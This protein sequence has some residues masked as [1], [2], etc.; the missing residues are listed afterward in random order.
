[1]RVISGK[2]RGTKLIGPEGL[3][4]RPTSDRIKESLFNMIGMDLYDVCFL[5]IFSG[6]G[7]IG[8]EALSRGAKE[9]TFIEQSKTAYKS[10]EANI[11][12]TKLSQQSSILN[13]SVSKALNELGYKNFNVIFMDPPYNKDMINHTLQLIIKN[14]LLL[15]GGYII[16]ERP[17]SYKIDD[18]EQLYLWK[19]KKYNM[20]TMSFLKGVQQIWK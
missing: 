6:S 3:E 19:E 2:A 9:A 16:V 17:T 20:T 14:K 15:S 12:K 5:D 8:I 7:A 13:M 10:I 11:K 18:L 4:T 1:M